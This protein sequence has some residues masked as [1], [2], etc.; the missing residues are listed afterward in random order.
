[1]HFRVYG[2][3]YGM[4]K[5]EGGAGGETGRSVQSACLCARAV[6]PSATH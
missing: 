4:L 5:L 6:L 2:D 3:A 1:V